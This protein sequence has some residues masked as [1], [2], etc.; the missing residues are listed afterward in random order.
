M[1]LVCSES[2]IQMLLKL[3]FDTAQGKRVVTCLVDTGA[4]ICLVRRK[5][6]VSSL[7]Q[8]T[9]NPVRLVSADGSPMQGG[10]KVVK[11]ELDFLAVPRTP[12]QPPGVRGAIVTLPFQGYGADIAYDIILSYQ[13]LRGMGMWVVPPYSCLFR[14]TGSVGDEFILG[15]VDIATEPRPKEGGGGPEFRPTSVGAN[16]ILV[17]GQEQI[18]GAPGP[19]RDDPVMMDTSVRPKT[20][21]G[22]GS[23]GGLPTGNH[24]S[25]EGSKHSSHDPPEGEAGIA[26]GGNYWSPLTSRP[27]KDKKPRAFKPKGGKHLPDGLSKELSNLNCAVSNTEKETDFLSPLN[28]TVSPRCSS[29]TSETTAT[30]FKALLG[31]D[32]T[33]TSFCQGSKTVRSNGPDGHINYSEALCAQLVKIDGKNLASTASSS[34]VAAPNDDE[35]SRF[36]D[37]TNLS[38]S[39]R[40][41]LRVDPGSE[42][43]ENFRDPNQNFGHVEIRQNPTGPIS[44]CTHFGCIQDTK[45]NNNGPGSA[46]SKVHFRGATSTETFDSGGGH[47]QHVV[48]P[49]DSQFEITPDQNDRNTQHTRRNDNTE[50]SPTDLATGTTESLEAPTSKNVLVVKNDIPRKKMHDESFELSG[51][52]DWVTSTYYVADQHV[53]DIFQGLGLHWDEAIQKTTR[54]CFSTSNNKRFNKHFTKHSS[55]AD[56]DGA[57]GKDWSKDKL[58]WINPPFER[59]QEVVDKIVHDGARAVVVAP[60]W[61]ETAPW[62]ETLNEM[63]ENYFEIPHH[64]KLF[65]DQF[66]IP[67]PQRHWKTTAFL[68]DGT[69]I[70]YSLS[71][72][73]EEEEEESFAISQVSSRPLQN[74]E[75]TTSLH[76]HSSFGHVESYRNRVVTTTDDQ[77]VRD[78][79]RALDRANIPSRRIRS[80]TIPTGETIHCPK[81]ASLVDK[82]KKDFAKTSLSG[83]TMANPPIRG[84]H[85][86]CMF[87]L[88]PGSQPRKARPC[89]LVGERE[90]AIA[91]LLHELHDRGWLENAVSDWGSPCFV[92]PK[93]GGYKESGKKSEWRLVVDY[94]WLNE[95]T[96]ADRHPIPLIE[97]MLE[98]MGSKKIFTILDMKHGFHQVPIPE[99]MRKYTAMVTPDGRHLQWRVMPMGIK[100][101]PS[102]FQRV[103]NWVLQDMPFATCYIDDILIASDGETEEELLANHEKHVR[104]V[105]Q[106]LA[107]HKMVAKMSKAAFFVREV[108][109]C[110][111]ILGGGT[112]R[113]VPGRLM[114]IQKWEKPKTLRELRAF[115][116]LINWYGIYVKNLAEISAPM[117]ELLKTPKGAAKKSKIRTLKWDEESTASF[118]ATKSAFIEG[119]QLFILNPDRPFFLRTD[120]SNYAVGAVLEQVDPDGSVTGVAGQHY[121]V[122][123]WSRKLAQ[124][125]LNWSPR[126]KEAYAILGALIKW[127]GW[128]GLQPVDVLTDHQ[129]LQRWHR[130]EIDTASGPLGRRAR[131]HELF[132][133]FNLAVTYIPGKNNPVADALSRWAYPACQA[134]QDVSKH[135]SAKTAEEVAAL[136]SQEEREERRWVGNVRLQFS[137]DD[138]GHTLKQWLAGEDIINSCVVESD[139]TFWWKSLGCRGPPP[140]HAGPLAVDITQVYSPLTTTP[141]RQ[142]SA[143]SSSSPLRLAQVPEVSPPLPISKI[144]KESNKQ[145]KSVHRQL[146]STVLYEANRIM[147]DHFGFYNSECETLCQRESFEKVDKDSILCI[148]TE[149]HFL[150]NLTVSYPTISEFKMGDSNPTEGSFEG[151]SLDIR[152]AEQSSKESASETL[153]ETNFIAENVSPSLH[154]FQE[155]QK[156]AKSPSD[157]EWL[158]ISSE[159]SENENKAQNDDRGNNA[160][161]SVPLHP[162]FDKEM[163]EKSSDENEPMESESDSL[164]LCGNVTS[165]PDPSQLLFNDWSEDYENCPKFGANW[166]QCHEAS[167][168]RASFPQGYRLNEKGDKMFHLNRLCVPEKLETTY[169]VALH[170]VALPH[171]SIDKLKTEVERRTAPIV[172]L[173]SKCKAVVQGCVTCQLVRPRIG[174]PAG[175]L[176]PHPTP[177]FVMSFV[178]VD[179]FKFEPVTDLEGTTKD[180]VLL[181]QCRL[182]GYM[183]AVPTTDDK[184]LTGE[185][186]AKLW[187]SQ[188]LSVFDVPTEISSDK[189]KEFVSRCWRTLCAHLGV[190]QAFGQAYRSSSHGKPENAGR[191]LINKL[192]NILNEA[193]VGLN[194]LEALPRALYVWHH[195]PGVTGFSPNQLVFGRNRG[196]QGLPFPTPSVHHEMSVFIGQMAKFD[197]VAHEFLKAEHEKQARAYNSKRK[198]VVSTYKPKDR[199]LVQR[200]KDHLQGA[201]KLN[202]LWEGP[203]EV[204]KNLGPH[205]VMVQ[206]G[207]SKQ[208]EFHID[209]LKLFLP[210]VLGRPTPLF[211]KARTRAPGESVL[212]D[213]DT[214]EVDKIL[215]HKVEPNGSVLFKARWKGFGP[216]HDSWEP[217]SSFFPGLCVPFV[218]YS[219]AKK[220]VF[221]MD[222]FVSPEAHLPEE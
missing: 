92:I 176:A 217:P 209:Q 131:W 148:Q 146:K 172:S 4:Q 218:H 139:S 190:R 181:F 84:P 59:M 221:D 135:G 22:R 77:V 140:P 170:E 204:I 205:S 95:C 17:R 167:I 114:A 171:C 153:V 108:E 107:D 161:I 168:G 35:K 9:S 79:K 112:R 141:D 128:I 207:P 25:L 93:R 34:E 71:S 110:G 48:N 130:E 14:E 155:L 3:G 166:R 147:A 42:K 121:P 28:F 169:I 64:W 206:T 126:E 45:E 52:P 13:W 220:I 56:G 193:N 32:G 213:E 151:A 129:S 199:V 152:V 72:E 214:W 178:V 177:P 89:R 162:D 101:A 8:P 29:H 6:F 78:V 103:M 185:K 144:K 16:R 202:T 81:T 156:S 69:I 120:A 57:F 66:G 125:Q 70:D 143:T 75:L 43:F 164:V 163:Q 106:R 12:K 134:F 36:T 49:D 2:R 149:D 180:C 208:S 145:T 80:V 47:P 37:K 194:W 23:G 117:C 200:P 187:L 39:G 24:H 96:V 186:A 40:V 19:S 165:P 109:F 118:H 173:L 15:R 82:I 183:V 85:G 142:P 5:S 150:K 195:T 105:L 196:G 211:Y 31:S 51:H 20:G 182:T 215:E 203:C 94:R 189:G 102:M 159:S 33:T 122:A 99:H 174:K 54:D 191:Q 104:A 192:R 87:E 138:F 67:L 30:E 188:W 175:E 133:K 157:E 86:A 91:E 7:F 137:E 90:A 100:N 179:V 98:K 60:C 1:G 210:D 160:V 61:D 27:K 97:D 41:R 222:H 50:P 219:K 46:A 10:D 68:V 154:E 11:G 197:S 158:I 198:P 201:S 44:E 63:S 74:K 26:S 127:A 184:G 212:E 216:K 111:H 38:G 116:G 53:V 119:L 136:I 88:L 83:A 132:S 123:F 73:D 55:G 58:L 113:P 76:T 62:F 21:S 115:T 18:R 65:V 124:G